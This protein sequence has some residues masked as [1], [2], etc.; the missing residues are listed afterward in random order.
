MENQGLFGSVHV[1]TGG[2]TFLNWFTGNLDFERD[3]YSLDKQ[4]AFASAEAKANRRWQEEMSNT[5]YQRAV[6]DLSSAGLNPYLLYSSASPS[7]TPSGAVASV[8]GA[9]KAKT[10]QGWQGLFSVLASLV[11]TAV[12]AGTSASIS[13]SKLSAQSLNNALKADTALEVARRNQLRE[14]HHYNHGRNY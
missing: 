14:L 1:P 10:P 12:S 9:P 8:Q 4:N 11:G 5:A 7:S 6:K 13:A 3:M 2:D